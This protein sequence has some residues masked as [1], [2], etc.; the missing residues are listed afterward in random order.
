[1][2]FSPPHPDHHHAD[3]VFL[4][5]A[6]ASRVASASAAMDLCSCTGIRTS[7]ISTLATRI[8][9]SSVASSSKVCFQKE[10]HCLEDMWPARVSG[11]FGE[12]VFSKLINDVGNWSD[13]AEGLELNFLLTYR[14]EVENH[15]VID[16]RKHRNAIYKLEYGSG[17]ARFV[18]PSMV[19]IIMDDTDTGYSMRFKLSLYCPLSLSQMNFFALHHWN[20]GL[21]RLPGKGCTSF[22]VV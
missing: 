14:E 12:A 3:P 18:T 19:V 20:V 21:Q 5:L 22:R 10:M 6:L 16:I 1:M 17:G 9:H 8:P 7:L 11:V 13:F 15:K 4:T 2:L